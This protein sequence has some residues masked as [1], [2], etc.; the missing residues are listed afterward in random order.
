MFILKRD[1]S[2]PAPDSRKQSQRVVL[3]R[4]KARILGA[5]DV[6]HKQTDVNTDGRF[7]DVAINR[8]A[9][10]T[11]DSTKPSPKKRA[12]GAYKR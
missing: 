1:E 8:S 2:K 5:C 11:L 3:G 4:R 10:N 6:L 7:Q 9:R 12:S